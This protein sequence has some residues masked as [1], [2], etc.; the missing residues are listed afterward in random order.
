MPGLSQSYPVYAPAPDL[1]AYLGTTVANGQ[2]LIE[3]ASGVIREWTKTAFYSTTA[4]GTPSDQR[5][6]DAFH[7][8][9]ILQAAAYYRAGIEP[10]DTAA[11][12]T[13]EIQ[14]RTLGS[15]SVTY[16]VNAS[17]TER[18]TALLDGSLSPEAASVLSSAGLL[19]T[20]IHTGGG[21]DYDLLLRRWV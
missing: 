8:A 14:S 18:R 9:A 21:R 5:V 15:R 11:V 6:A 19:S 17:A 13:P 4:E 7:D 1:D 3:R 16:A 10:G 2:A 12:A 20:S